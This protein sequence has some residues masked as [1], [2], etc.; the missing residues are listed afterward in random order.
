MTGANVPRDRA[1]LEERSADTFADRLAEAIAEL[2]ANRVSGP[3]RRER[4]P[5]TLE[6]LIAAAIYQELP[7]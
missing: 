7:R 1:F 6:Q 4:Q 5:E 3:A 2:M